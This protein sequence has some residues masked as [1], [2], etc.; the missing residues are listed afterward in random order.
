MI[1]VHG[2]G[3]D[4][5]DAPTH[6]PRSQLVRIIRPRVEEVVELVRDRLRAA[7]FSAPGRAPVV[8]TGGAS[9]LV[10]LPE[11]PAGHGG[12]GPH[13]SAAGHPGL[14]EA[15]KGPAFSAA[16]GSS[17]STRRWRTRSISSHGATGPSPARER[18]ATSR[19]SDA[20]SARASE[21]TAGTPETPSGW[22]RTARPE[23]APPEGGVKRNV[24]G[25]RGSTPWPFPCRRRT[26]GNSS[27][28][29]PSS[30][31]RSRRQ[32]RQQHDRVRASRLRVR[33]AN[34][35][36]QA[37]TSSKAERVIQMGLGV[38][39]GLGAGFAPVG[40]LGRRRRGDRRDP[41]PALGRPH[42]LHHRRHGRRP[43]RGLPP[44]SPARRATWASSPSA[45]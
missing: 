22:A 10:G 21:S 36:A 45:S 40:R 12:P 31:R 23:S 20:G 42:V 2:V 3:E 32:C 26:S 28:A 18:T 41:R 29:S 8:L 5:G 34:T 17:S 16:V 33:V 43:A 15:A 1:A 37:L 39:Q 14:P 35:D 13:R 19:A 9:Q 30:C 38:T 24:K 44:S 11:V 27:P 4:E 7:G 25:T 6:V